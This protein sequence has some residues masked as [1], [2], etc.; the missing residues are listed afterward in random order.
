MIALMVG[1]TRPTNSPSDTDNQSGRIYVENCNFSPCSLLKIAHNVGIT[2][3][4]AQ[5]I[6]GS[7]NMIDY[8]KIMTTN[9]PPLRPKSL[10]TPI[11]NVIVSMLIISNE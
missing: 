2:H 11:S 5:I 4:K 1:I 6:D 8:T 10:I 9:P 7:T 3:T